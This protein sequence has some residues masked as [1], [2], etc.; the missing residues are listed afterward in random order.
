MVAPVNRPLALLALAFASGPESAEAECR[1][2]APAATPEARTHSRPLDIQV[3]TA[4]DFSRAAHGGETGG[5]IAVDERSGRRG[6]SGGL[7]DLGGIAVRGVVRLTGEPFARVRVSLPRSIMLL[8]TEGDSAE[9]IDLRTDLSGDPALD[10][11]G[12]L[13]F[14]FGGKMVVVPGAAGDFRGRIPIVA[15]YQ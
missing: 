1:L 2:C 14:G 7:V 10:A 3:E 12:H 5:S 8:S 15:D 9:V 11:T 13:Q 4:L 6:V